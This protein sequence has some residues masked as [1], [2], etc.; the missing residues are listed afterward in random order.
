MTDPNNPRPEIID[1]GDA[2]MSELCGELANRCFNGRVRQFLFDLGRGAD[3]SSLLLALPEIEYQK[4]IQDLLE[5][6]NRYLERARAAER[7]VNEL[8]AT[9][10]LL[11]KEAVTVYGMRDKMK[12]LGSE[13]SKLSP[14]E[15]KMHLIAVIE[16]A[17]KVSL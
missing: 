13:Y 15:L 9:N 11:R 12:S 10:A 8:E 17:G 5:A 2:T 16:A 3:V 4:R 1:I 7:M 14:E 6:N